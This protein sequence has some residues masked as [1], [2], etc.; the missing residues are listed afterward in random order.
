[1]ES[2]ARKK[3]SGLQIVTVSYEIYKD[4]IIEEEL[5]DETYNSFYTFLQ[6]ME[7]L[8]R[9]ENY[10]IIKRFTFLLKVKLIS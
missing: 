3:I 7:P 6:F 8:S 2:P 10:I 9:E 5:L 4:F 1:M